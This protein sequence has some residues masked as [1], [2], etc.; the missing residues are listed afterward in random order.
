M[1]GFGTGSSSLPEGRVVAEVRSTNQRFLDV[2]ARLPREIADL[3]MLAEQS[4]RERLR[5]GRVEILVHTEGASTLSPTLDKRRAASA[6]RALAELRDELSPGAELPLSL[7]SAVP[8][9]FGPPEESEL[10]V[11]RDAAKAAI[12]GAVTSMLAMCELEG[13]TLARDLRGRCETLR[14]L[15]DGVE[16]R[17]HGSVDALRERL[18]E[19][20]GRLVSETGF[21]V[22]AARLET[23][24][25]VLADRSDVREE[26]TRLHSHLQQFTG[27]L[28]TSTEGLLGRRLDFLIQ[29]MLREANTLGSK[30]GDAWISQQVVSI[31]VELERLREQVQNVE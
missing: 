5:R 15:F 29:E 8:D 7:L 12:D 3:T 11:L 14:T 1:T 10:S 17:T 19:R 26:L 22:D 30:A 21:A 27:L 4:V 18:R 13:A 25:A 6:L 24:L 23:E 20:V 28:A 16:R 9:L 2:R 31:K